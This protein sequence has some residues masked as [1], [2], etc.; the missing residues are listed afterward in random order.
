MVDEDRKGYAEAWRITSQDIELQGAYDWFADQ[1]APYRPCRVFDVGCGF[2][3]GIYAML[4][5]YSDIEIVSIEENPHCIDL[6]H[7]HILKNMGINADVKRRLK[8]VP[9][10]HPACAYKNKYKAL[11]YK[12]AGRVC[13]IESDLL[14]DTALIPTF[15][16]KNHQFDGLT[17]WLA[18]AAPSKRHCQNFEGF[19]KDPYNLRLVTQNIAYELADKIVKPGGF[20]NL[21]DRANLGNTEQNKDELL[22]SHKEQA[23][24]TSFEPVSATSRP[25]EINPATQNVILGNMDSGQFG[26]QEVDLEFSSVISVKR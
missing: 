19:V 13:I 9:A 16:Q 1:L 20:I 6:A 22:A 21:V 10:D 11:N 18:G 26:A 4:R 2:G 12:K 15:S 14:D 3:L 7:E 8:A 25:Y 5:K 17:I 23:E 24:G